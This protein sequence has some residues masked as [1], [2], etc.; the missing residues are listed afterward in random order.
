LFSDRHPAAPPSLLIEGGAVRSGYSQRG[1]ARPARPSSG[2]AGEA[3][4]RTAQT[5]GASIS[6]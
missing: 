4:A 3:R 6:A 5:S 1:S 2:Q